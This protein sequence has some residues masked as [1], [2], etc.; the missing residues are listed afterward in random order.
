MSIS[1]PYVSFFNE[2][3]YY[4]TT[5]VDLFLGILISCSKT[6]LIC[7]G[8]FLLIVINPSRCVPGCY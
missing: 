3:L 1:K 7:S 5:P 8:I 2:F 6:Q 4:V